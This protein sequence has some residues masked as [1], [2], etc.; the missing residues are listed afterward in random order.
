[1]ETLKTVRLQ[2]SAA[3]DAYRDRKL[4]DAIETLLSLHDLLDVLA[5]AMVNEQIRAA[6]AQVDRLAEIGLVVADLDDMLEDARRSQSPL[7]SATLLEETW[8]RLRDMLEPSGKLLVR[9]SIFP[10]GKKTFLPFQAGDTL[11]QVARTLR[12]RYRKH[13]VDYLA[14]R[15]DTVADPDAVDIAFFSSLV[16]ED[17][18]MALLPEHA[19]VAELVA[20]ETDGL[21]WFPVLPGDTPSLFGVDD[22]DD[23]D[24]YMNVLENFTIESDID[25][26]E[27]DVRR[28]R[29]RLG[30]EVVAP[31]AG[32]RSRAHLVRGV[33]TAREE[34]ILL[35]GERV[36]IGRGKEN[37]IQ[38]LNDS[39][40]SRYHCRIVREG[41]HYFVED[42]SSSNG[43]L[44]NGEKVMR[45]A[46][47]GG[48][49]LTV[50]N[51]LFRFVRD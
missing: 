31:P 11:A 1:M 2:L 12:A 39:K 4:K 20:S 21:L 25:Q 16:W 40:V 3:E 49:S 43:T 23:D 5:S 45:H 6:R 34:R 37:D 19:K 18:D 28:L 38:I 47:L 50:G 36:T 7:Q 13:I 29:E 14:R 8:S 44:L 17:P 15:G 10:R 22:A 32:W 42:N 26:L 9:S 48:E 24:G 30:G 27:A 35:T 41:E 46:L 33:G 51:T